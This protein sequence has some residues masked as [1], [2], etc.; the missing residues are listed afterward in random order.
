MPEAIF[1][2]CI[3]FAAVIAVATDLAIVAAL[4]LR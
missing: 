4:L 1:R 2:I 3:V